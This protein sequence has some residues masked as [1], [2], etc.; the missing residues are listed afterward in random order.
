MQV[1]GI[2][3]I[4]EQNLEK[5]IELRIDYYFNAHNRRIKAFINSGGA[6]A[7]I[8]SSPDVL[9]IKPGLVKSAGIPAPENQGIIHAMLLKKIPVIHLL[10]I[11]GLAQ[12][13]N[14]PWDPARQ[15]EITSQSVRF[16]A[17]HH[18][19]VLIISLLGIFWFAWLM[20]RY[21]KLFNSRK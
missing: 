7:N 5:N 10:Y 13:Y 19:G 16:N 21:R 18:Y 9:N 3:M 1:A 17:N 8:G 2:P 11:K 6:Y 12:K 15:P 14:L 4:S 20:I